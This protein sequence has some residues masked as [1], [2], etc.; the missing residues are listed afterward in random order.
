MK[1]L[2]NETITKLIRQSK[3]FK[4][5]RMATIR[6]RTVRLS[7]LPTTLYHLTNIWPLRNSKTKRTSLAGLDENKRL[8]LEKSPSESRKSNGS[9]AVSRRKVLLVYVIFE[10][11]LVPLLTI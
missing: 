6:K 1:Q 5:I 8:H 3:I 11:G 10:E 2:I 4:G 9:M 7:S